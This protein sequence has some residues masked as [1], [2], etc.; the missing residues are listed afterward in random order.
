MKVLWLGGIILPKIAEIEGLTFN[1]MN[2]WLIKLSEE[3]KSE[4]KID[5]VYVFDSDKCIEG[6]TE[7][8]S[9]YGIKCDK[10]SSKRFG[11]EYISQAE[12]ILL[13]EK[14]DIVHIW[15]TE[16][17][18]SL[19][20]VEACKNIG[21]E[22]SVVISIQGLVSKYFYHYY[23]YLPQ[24]VIA[25]RT[26]RDVI[27]GNITDGA[28][29]FKIRGELEKEAICGVKHVIG[30]TEWDRAC[31][32]DINPN[33]DYHFNNETLRDEFYSGQW[34]YDTCEKHSIFCSQGHYPIKGIHLVIEALHRVVQE[35]PDAHLYIGGKD[36][37]HLPFWKQ[38]GY[39]AYLVGLIK[40]YNLEKNVTFTGFLNANQMKNRY[41][42]ANVFVSAS[43]IENSPNSLGEAMILGVPC[44]S[45]RVGGVHN[46][47]EH[48]KD[49][50]LYP[51]DETYMLSYYI[52]D[53]FRNNERAQRYGEN[54]R[55]KAM[56]THDPEK[57]RNDLIDIY[58][59][60]KCQADFE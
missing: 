35:Y 45:S 16:G 38:S 53:V 24:Y 20:M 31:A 15:G 32:W 44:I 11:Y 4:Q 41:L 6:T 23:A 7:Y 10:A 50:Y 58:E 3:L 33:L 30:R 47:M 52:C 60:I 26:L 27:K 12:R 1:H 40:K 55:M 2:G 34:S 19:A 43:S 21:I 8:Y 25:S 36:Y 29:E 42:K 56:K 14:P 13:K 17:S 51:A 22:E 57:N 48:G 5:L 59:R 37:L 28:K 39:G 46:L 18:H 9:Y 54:A 49:G